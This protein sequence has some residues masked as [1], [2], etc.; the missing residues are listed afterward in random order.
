MNEHSSRLAR[1]CALVA[2]LGIGLVALSC[3]GGSGPDSVVGPASAPSGDEGALTASAKLQAQPVCHYD[4]TLGTYTTL[5]LNPQA[6]SAHVPGHPKD[7]AGACVA[8]TCPCFTTADIDALAATCPVAP[9]GSCYLAYSLDLLCPSGAVYLGSFE[10]YLGATECATI[11]V[12]GEVRI[13]VT[14]AQLAACQVAIVTSAH[15]PPYCQ[16]L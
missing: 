7:Y 13:S 16:R 1:T 6:L 10:A 11:T 14:S 8:A 12:A 15:Y 3:G 2:A 5:K 4:A 9:V